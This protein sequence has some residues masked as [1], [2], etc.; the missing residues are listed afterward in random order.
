MSSRELNSD[1]QLETFLYA[2]NS[3]KLS[4]LG[5]NTTLN[6]IYIIKIC[7]MKPRALHIINCS[8][9]VLEFNKGEILQFQVTTGRG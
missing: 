5:Q 9:G 7:L 2:S 1:K 3:L 4:S 6:K 8:G